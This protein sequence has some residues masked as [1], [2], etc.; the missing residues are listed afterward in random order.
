MTK[1][2]DYSN[3][4][5]TWKAMRKLCNDE[6]LSKREWE[7]ISWLSLVDR[8]N[9]QFEPGNVRWATSEAERAD[10]LKFYQSLSPAVH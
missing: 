6:P 2:K 5:R 8:N 7:D 9:L 1:S 3:E 4:Y 10:N